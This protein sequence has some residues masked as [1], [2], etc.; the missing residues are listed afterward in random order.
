VLDISYTSRAEW[1]RLTA[2]IDGSVVGHIELAPAGD[3]LMPGEIT[4]LSGSS[5]LTGMLLSPDNSG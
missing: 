4:G 5:K 1:H 3:A 2:R